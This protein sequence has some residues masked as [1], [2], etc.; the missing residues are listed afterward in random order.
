M[1]KAIVF[2]CFGVLV[3]DGWLAFKHRHFDAD[4]HLFDQVTE[5]NQ[6][7]DAAAISYDTFI[8]RV[9][10]LAKVNKDDVKNEIEQNLPNLELFDFIS[11]ELKNKYPLGI[12][13]NAAANWLDELFTPE[14]LALF[15]T[16]A[17]SF[18]IGA[19]KPQAIAYVTIAKKLG[20]ELNECVFIDDQLRY[21]EGAAAVGMKTIHYTDFDSFKSQ[22]AIALN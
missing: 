3:S 20:V 11:T 2:D 15:D 14:Q 22:L 8:S 1:I 17:L 18:E 5:I 9:A 4:K 13:S 10:E 19:I 21:C 6:Q 12:L 16:Y 7:V